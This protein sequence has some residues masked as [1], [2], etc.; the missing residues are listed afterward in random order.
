MKKDII[1][2]MIKI[3]WL[4]HILF[5]SI[6]FYLFL[7]IFSGPAG[8]HPIDWLYTGVFLSTV[9]AGVYFNLLFLI[10]V[11]LGRRKY[12]LYILFLSV[13]IP[14]SAELNILAFSRFYDV[15]FPGYYFISDYG[16]VEV[17]KTVVAFILLTS[18]LKFSKGWFLLAETRARMEQLQKE[19][20]ETELK[21]LKSQINPH[22][23]FNS[24]NSI[25]ALVIKISDQAPEAILKLAGFLRY[26]LYETSGD[27]VPL[28]NEL[29]HLQDYIDLQKLR[30][31]INATIRFSYDGDPAGKKLAPLLLLP[32]IENSFKH[33]IKGE[34]GPSFVNA[35][36]Q[37]NARTMEFNIENN[38][39]N[40]DPV[41]KNSQGGIGLDNLKKRLDRLYPG[42]HTLAIDDSGRS[43]TVKLI[44][45]LAGENEM[46]DR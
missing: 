37:I 27:Y 11:F 13:T 1:L 21:A 7:G 28:E 32:L 22:F 6:T 30:A 24:L 35:N 31:G 5:W 2:G 16:Y 41:E 42:D 44:I 46:P 29:R 39:G 17:L 19:Q 20:V 18:L 4:Q 3:R 38:I 14:A 12:F 40:A 26:I 43:F 36:L 25:Y 23:L 15:L 45:P 9:A 10:P 33:G 34:T 8:S